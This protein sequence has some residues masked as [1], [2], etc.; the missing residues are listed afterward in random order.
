[1]GLCLALRQRFRSSRAAP[2]IIY[3]DLLRSSTCLLHGHKTVACYSCRVV[4]NCF[5]MPHLHTE[6]FFNLITPKLS[7]QGESFAEKCLQPEP[8]PLLLDILWPLVINSLRNTR[9]LMEEE[10]NGRRKTER[11]RERWT[12]RMLGRGKPHS[13]PRIPS[14]QRISTSM[15]CMDFYH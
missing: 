11:A 1:M 7:S 2:I 14:Q 5:A 10:K 4:C 9:G 12:E 6:R 8:R 15:P 3:P 13:D